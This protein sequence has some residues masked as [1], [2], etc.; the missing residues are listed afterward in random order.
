MSVLRH[1]NVSVPAIQVSFLCAPIHT[2][3]VMVSLAGGLAYIRFGNVKIEIDNINKIKFG[4][5]MKNR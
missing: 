1:E 5:V 2:A 3:S 4:E